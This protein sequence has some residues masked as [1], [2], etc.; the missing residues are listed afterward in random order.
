MADPISALIAAGTAITEMFAGL[1]TAG[2][3]GAGAAGTA[4][5]TAAP[6]VLTSGLASGLGAAGTAGLGGAATAGAGL[7]LDAAL[8]GGAELGSTG[9][10]FGALGDAAL[11]VGGGL[12]AGLEGG[13]GTA[14]TAGTEAGLGTSAAALAAPDIGGAGLATGLESGAGTLG[15]EFAAGGLEGA[16]TPEV[17]T[18]TLPQGPGA[19]SLLPEAGTLGVGDAVGSITPEVLTEGLPTAGVEFG[20]AGP[21]SA[22]GKFLADPT[23]AGGAEALWANKDLIGA[24][25][26]AFPLLAGSETM[27]GEDQLAALAQ[28]AQ[29]TGAQFS[30]GQLPPGMQSGLDSANAAAKA[31]M[32]SMFASRGMSGSSSEVAALANID[33]TTAKHGAEIAMGLIDRGIAANKMSAALYTTIM[34]KAMMD[35]DRLGKSI[36]RISAALAA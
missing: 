16:L 20:A 33:Q 2:A 22:I 4:A 28:Q 36:G 11:G 21:E 18:S 25:A 27:P 10:L 19:A 7:G 31:A 14:L 8:L 5:A 29:S 32:R 9:G 12:G 26:L 3:A 23:L 34:Q 1:G 24:G 35:D 15:S 6:T 30:S 17:L 13:L